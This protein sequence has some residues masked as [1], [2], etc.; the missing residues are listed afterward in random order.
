MIKQV[1]VYLRA[2]Q[3]KLVDEWRLGFAVGYENTLVKTASISLQAL[4]KITGDVLS[5]GVVVKNRWGPLSAS[6]SLSGSYGWYDSERFVNLVG[7]G[8]S[9]KSDQ[10][11]GS[12]VIKRHEV[13][14]FVWLAK[15]S[16][17]NP[18]WMSLRHGCI[19]VPIEKVEPLVRTCHQQ[20]R[21]RMGFVSHPGA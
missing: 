20:Q 9:A 16:I 21:Q 8:D 18:W 10:N 3:S 7:V 19:L 4:D 17:S 5:L 12:L 11:V 1:L 2:F 6:L 14:N 15:I 13:F